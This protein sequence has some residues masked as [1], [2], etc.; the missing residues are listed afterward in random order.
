MKHTVGGESNLDNHSISP[1]LSPSLLC[2]EHLS[3]TAPW[4]CQHCAQGP[5]GHLTANCIKPSSP[6]R[7]LSLTC[8]CLSPTHQ[9]PCHLGLHSHSVPSAHPSQPCLHFSSSSRPPLTS[10]GVTGCQSYGVPQ[11]SGWETK[12]WGEGTCPKL[13]IEAVAEPG[14]EL[15]LSDSRSSALPH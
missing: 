11:A 15:R 12:L 13:P 10:V 5:Q 6:T 8:P 1:S 9:A 2:L 3:K 14:L 7:H 4:L